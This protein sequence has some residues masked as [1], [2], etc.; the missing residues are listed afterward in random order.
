M[1][2]YVYSRLDTAEGGIKKM[3]DGSEGNTHVE[4]KKDKEWK[5]K[6]GKNYKGLV[7]MF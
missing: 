3:E 6:Q 7:E 1:F 4:I 2:G 5:I